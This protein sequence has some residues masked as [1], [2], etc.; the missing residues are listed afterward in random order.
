MAGGG[1]RNSVGNTAGGGGSASSGSLSANGVLRF[2]NPIQ[3]P[4]DLH[5]YQQQQH[6]QQQQMMQQVAVAAAAA[7]AV[8]QPRHNR[9]SSSRQQHIKLAN[10][11][12]PP[13]GIQFSAV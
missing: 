1:V 7:S 2:P 9:L 8:N 5:Q 3:R 13:Q 4:V 10:Q 12:Y 11:Y 6:Q